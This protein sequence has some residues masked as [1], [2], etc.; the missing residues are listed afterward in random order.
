MKKKAGTPIKK[1]K[2]LAS[3]NLERARIF[4]LKGKV[5]RA[6]T[7]VFVVLLFILSVMY[8]FKER[9]IEKNSFEK[10]VA[11]LNSKKIGEKKAIWSNKKAFCDQF[12]GKCF[13]GSEIPADTDLDYLVFFINQISNSGIDNGEFSHLVD[14]PKAEYNTEEKILLK[15]VEKSKV[16]KAK[17]VP[18]ELLPTLPQFTFAILGDSQWW[19]TKDRWTDQF[20]TILEKLKDF[21]PEFILG[22]GDLSSMEGCRTADKCAAYFERWRDEVKVVSPNVYPAIGNHDYENGGM[23]LWQ[24]IFNTPN[25]GP[26][27]SR[28]TTYSFDY[29]NSHFVFLNS[30]QEDQ[31]LDQ[32]VQM[33]WMKDD[34]EN[35][36]KRNVF[37][38][39]HRPNFPS[40][41]FSQTHM[42]QTFFNNDVLAYFSGHIHTYCYR[43]VSAAN[44]DG[45]GDNIIQHFVIGNSGSRTMPSIIG[46]EQASSLAHFAIVSIKGPDMNVKIYDF[47]GNEL[48]ALNFKN[49]HYYD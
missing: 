16:I 15:T 2:V 18:Q 40:Q 26:A 32:S 11:Y 36:S 37:I 44:I 5:L 28:G 20:E 49:K 25:D 34:L 19:P 27:E 10:T 4:T 47:E 35:T 48:Y 17:D 41:S 13:W 38:I 12:S 3:K 7:A 39:N 6:M 42:W 23:E 1:I 22:M 43:P 21:H 30:E 24:K 29:K 8:V 33:K 31:P 46:C 14:F 45:A 9:E